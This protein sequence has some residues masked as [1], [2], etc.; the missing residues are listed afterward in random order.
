MV[1]ITW[2]EPNIQNLL[3]IASN[4]RESD[5]EELKASN[6]DTPIDVL[7]ESYELSSF[8]EVIYLDD[9]PAIVYGLTPLSVLAGV[10]APWLL[11]TPALDKIPKLL[12]R[13]SPDGVAF[14]LRRYR[15]LMN[16]VDARNTRTIRW[17]AWLGF[18]IHPAVPYGL[19]G[20]PFHLFSKSV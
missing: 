11:A 16:Y 19:R 3:Y 10:A 6:A 17:L 2:G 13:Y 12:L 18:D 9:E 1:N 15:T 20:E 5:R 8:A 14:M 4:L 7:F